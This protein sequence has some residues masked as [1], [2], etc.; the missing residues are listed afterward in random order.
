MSG[1]ALYLALKPMER[2][3]ISILRANNSLKRSGVLTVLALRLDFLREWWYNIDRLISGGREYGT[4][5]TR[6]CCR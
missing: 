3:W 5:D 4:D 2:V 1:R 6:A